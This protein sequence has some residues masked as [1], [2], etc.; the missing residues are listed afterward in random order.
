M[1]FI[2]DQV[3]VCKKFASPS[4]NCSFP[5]FQVSQKNEFSSSS[6]QPWISPR[7][8]ETQGQDLDETVLRT[9]VALNRHSILSTAIEGISDLKDI[10]D[11]TGVSVECGLLEQP[12][13]QHV[14]KGRG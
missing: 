8:Y 14:Q 11:Q 10:S 5:I 6:L 7:P 3:G 2:R 12:S 1:D 13:Q 9:T 4:S